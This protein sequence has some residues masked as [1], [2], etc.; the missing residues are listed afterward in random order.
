MT[1]EHA[2]NRA[3]LNAQQRSQRLDN[4]R[5][6]VGG[7]SNIWTA[8]EAQFY[9]G[10]IREATCGASAKVG[11]DKGRFWER[12]RLAVLQYGAVNAQLLGAIRAGAEAGRNRST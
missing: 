1:V 7:Y 3:V 2:E 11:I 9:P 10:M 12:F 6:L 4:A 8:I 5:P